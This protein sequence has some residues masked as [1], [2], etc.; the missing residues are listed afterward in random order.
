MCPH[1][2]TAAPLV[3]RGISAYCSAC[4]A[5]RTVLSGSSLTHAG[6]PA[7]VGG[8]MVQVVGWLAL[9]FGL[10]FSAIV[11]L[12]VWV[13]APFL[14]AAITF[15]VLSVMTLAV[16]FALKKGGQKLAESGDESRDMRRE[17]ALFALAAAQGGTLQ[18]GQA[19]TALDCPVNEAD[20]LL[21]KLAKSREDV[22]IEVGDQGEVF[23][24]F[25]RVVTFSPSGG[26]QSATFTHPVQPRV[27]V[28]ER[29]NDLGSQGPRASDRERQKNAIDAEFEAIEDEKRAEQRR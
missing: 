28:D 11:S 16:F 17:Q 12:I 7:Q 24:T 8:A 23:Y 2:R 4:G 6:Q 15:G 9:L 22:G 21:T 25:A 5:K 14:T 1:C 10:S 20:A 26:V 13:F 29:F 3:Y 18:A 19:A 27:R